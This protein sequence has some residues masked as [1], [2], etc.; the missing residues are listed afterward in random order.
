MIPQ[1]ADL[2]PVIVVCPACGFLNNA[3][4]GAIKSVCAKCDEPLSIS[5]EGEAA[6]QSREPEG[7]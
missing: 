4:A 1:E 2:K 3:K 7:S 5:K 6:V